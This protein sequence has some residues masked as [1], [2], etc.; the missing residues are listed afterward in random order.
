MR[1]Q[2]HSPITSVKLIENP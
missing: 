1:H 2:S